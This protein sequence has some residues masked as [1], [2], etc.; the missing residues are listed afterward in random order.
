[1]YQVPVINPDEVEEDKPEE[2]EDEPKEAEEQAAEPEEA[3]MEEEVEE[4]IIEPDE[5]PDNEDHEDY[6]ESVVDDNEESVE[7]YDPNGTR[8][9][10]V[11]MKNK[12]TSLKKII[13]ESI[14]L[15]KRANIILLKFQK[16]NP[17]QGTSELVW[18][19][20]DNNDYE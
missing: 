20:F 19:P 3:K 10:Q 13:L 1:M 18:K 8:E 7:L 17:E 4:Q 5:R 16:E 6:E 9:V 14:G 12:A 15:Y 11:N 2:Q